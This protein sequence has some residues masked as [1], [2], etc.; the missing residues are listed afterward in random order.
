MRPAL[1]QLKDLLASMRFAIALLSVISIAAV[2]GTV[3]R[4]REPLPNYVNQF[5]PFWAELF[6]ALD[7]YT[8]YSAA[9][10]LLILAFLVLS[11]SLCIARQAP[12]IARDWRDAKLS[13]RAQSLR[14][15]PHHAEAALKVDAAAAPALALQR[16]QAAGW[17]A[18]IDARPEGTLLAARK[19]KVNKLGYLAAHGAIVLICLGGL[20]DGDL[21]VQAAMRLQGKQL[22]EG[23]GAVEARHVLETS[24]PAFRANLFVPEGG[25]G[26][27]ARID[28]PGG[29]V[30][31]R[32]PFELELKRF[33]V[34]YYDTGM[35]KLFASEVLLRDADGERS[36][37]IEVNKPLIHKGY[38]LY[39][40]SFDDGGS[41][42][43]LRVEPLAAGQAQTLQGEVGG[44]A[45]ALQGT[46]LRLEP[47]ALR[48][49]NVEDFGQVRGSDE[50]ARAASQP[51]GLGTHLGSAARDPAAKS[52]RNIGP[53][54]GYK[55]RDAAGQAR[56]YNHY[57][58]PTELDGVSVFLLGVRESQAE[59]FRYLR[60]PADENASLQGWLRL[61]RALLDAELRQQAAQAYARAASPRADTQQ[62]LLSSAVRVLNLFA[63]TERVGEV[64]GGLP[65]LSAFIERDVPQPE[66]ERISE[67]L[68][69]ILN[70]SLLELDRLAR[71]RQGVALPPPDEARQKF[72]AQA[73]MALS[74]AAFFP[75]P[76]LVTLESFEQRQASVFQVARAP[77][78]KL[79]YLGAVLLI[80]GVFAML[81]IRERRLW[82]W[83][84][85][86][87]Q[88]GTHWQL[89][90]ASPRTGVDLDAEFDRL[91]TQ[92]LS[93]PS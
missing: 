32:L 74:D 34:E 29:S 16:L 6:G 43:Q 51:A 8:V 64:E 89:A 57:M 24:T 47:S 46:E 58:L 23:S 88:G 79:V 48:V 37:R 86:D 91:R 55:L 31:Q 67:V 36:A 72:M 53:S 65:G 18:R 56:E 59:E 78:Q 35:P 73:V 11:T 50:A 83:I 12:K 26:E 44:A 7:L 60:A 45:L 80:V 15:H 21:L 63:G 68:L 13:I 9:W 81:Y 90:L 82:L 1:R 75:A 41:R 25:K 66:R 84:A 27:I 5:G 40:S 3:V 30:W 69:R 77:G 92:L 4:Q 61:R 93:Q 38:A 87:A 71:E 49:I 85:A 28:L 10:F 33:I 2:I 70:G 42:L 20:L 14:A 62:Q 54:F 52:L 76:L 22:H 39:Q 19:G 17:Q